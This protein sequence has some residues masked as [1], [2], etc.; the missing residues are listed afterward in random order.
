M[1]LEDQVMSA[2][3]AA[4]AFLVQEQTLSDL[5]WIRSREHYLKSHLSLIKA[6]DLVLEIAA[7]EKL[8]V[9]IVSAVSTFG[10]C[11][12]SLPT[13]DERG[14]HDSHDNSDERARSLLTPECAHNAGR[15]VE[16]HDFRL[17]GDDYSSRPNISDLSGSIESKHANETS[18]SAIDW[19]LRAAELMAQIRDDVYAADLDLPLSNPTTEV[20]Q[21]VT[22]LNRNTQ[23]ANSLGDGGELTECTNASPT[24][25]LRILGKY[26]ISWVS[27]AHLSGEF[28]STPPFGDHTC[29]DAPASLITLASM[30][31]LPCAWNSHHLSSSPASSTS[32][33]GSEATLSEQVIGEHERLRLSTAEFCYRDTHAFESSGRILWS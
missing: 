10:F 20:D 24:S 33:P 19:R 1:I 14:C 11:C 22:D 27:S 15:G 7:D 9:G 13:T 4:P 26:V 16:S 5:H 21:S 3:D 31:P 30:I 12:P 32:N 2:L 18:A 29:P 28:L 17:W 6:D 23:E 8:T 25:F